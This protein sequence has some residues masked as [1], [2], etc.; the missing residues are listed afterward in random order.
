M[1]R[2]HLKRVVNI[3]FVVQSCMCTYPLHDVPLI[4]SLAADTSLCLQ[5][6]SYQQTTFPMS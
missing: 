2:G 3:L 6:V 1:E 4:V 5:N